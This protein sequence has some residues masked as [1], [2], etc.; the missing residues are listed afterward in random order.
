MGCA[1][2]RTERRNC[3]I[4]N[5][6]TLDVAYIGGEGRPLSRE[7]CP[8]DKIALDYAVLKSGLGDGYCKEM[9]EIFHVNKKCELDERKEAQ[10]RRQLKDVIQLL[11]NIVKFVEFQGRSIADFKKKLL[12]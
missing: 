5:Y 11:Q 9:S 4:D 7:L 3:D 10:A 2:S 8:V 12:G 1:G 6:N